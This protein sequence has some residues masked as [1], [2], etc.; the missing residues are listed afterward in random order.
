MK[1]QK[2]KMPLNYTKIQSSLETIKY[3]FN[4]NYNRDSVTY[5]WKQKFLF[6]FQQSPFDQLGVNIFFLKC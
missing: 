6:L 2:T 3:I 1:M 4:H 5:P